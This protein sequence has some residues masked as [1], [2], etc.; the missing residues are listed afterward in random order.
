MN[1]N[2]EFF[3]N[4]LSRLI[5]E[6][7]YRYREAEQAFDQTIQD[8]WR[9]VAHAMAAVENNNLEWEQQFYSILED[10]RFLPGGRILAGSDVPYQVTLFNCFVMGTIEDLSTVFSTHS[11]KGR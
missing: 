3:S 11:K 9:R 6:S 7:K 10:F 8:S 1:D 5:W 4:D 2:S